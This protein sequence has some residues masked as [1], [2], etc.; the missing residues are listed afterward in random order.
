MSLQFDTQSTNDQHSKHST[1]SSTTPQTTDTQ[2]QQH[3][4]AQTP[5]NIQIHTSQPTDSENDEISEYSE[6]DTNH[7]QTNPDTKTAKPQTTRR[8]PHR[9]QKQK[10]KKGNYKES[11]SSPSSISSNNTETGQEHDNEPI[12]PHAFLRYDKAWQ[13]I[14][15]I[16]TIKQR[17]PSKTELEIEKHYHQTVIPT[18]Q[19]KDNNQWGDDITEPME[20]HSRIWFQNIQGLPR[21]SN[22]KFRSVVDTMDD[23]SVSIMGFAEP[24]LSMTAKRKQQYQ[25]ILRNQ[26]GDSHFT[27]SESNLIFPSEYKPGGTITAAVGK[28]TTRVTG[29][30]V[31]PHGLGR[32][33]YITLQSKKKKLVTGVAQKMAS[34]LCFHRVGA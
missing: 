16:Q 9:H 31:D 34:T 13:H 23:F 17:T 32:W 21:K 1:I 26:F 3:H 15:E 25:K 10:R 7:P 12:P 6:D 14:G 5:K 2:S 18:A 19:I 20:R 22:D 8:N 27:A 4:T 11:D 33:S 30:G 24:N 29:R 28:W